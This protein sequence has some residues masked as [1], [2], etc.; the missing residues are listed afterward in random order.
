MPLTVRAGNAPAK[1]LTLWRIVLWMILLLAMLGCLQYIHHA[2]QVWAQLQTLPPGDEGVSVLRGMLA[3]DIGY[4]LVAFSLIVLCAGGILRQAW[5]RP[6]LQVAA[7]LLAGWA[8]LSGI[9]L[10]QQWND[11]MH[12]SSDALTGPQADAALQGVLAHARRGYQ[13]AMALKVA[14][15]PILLWLAWRLGQPA[16]RAQF[17]TRSRNGSARVRL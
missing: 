2:Q 16:V 4:L 9:W 13:M 3:W 15:I 8:A 10:M 6:L 14:A 17:R 7:V 5:A 11:F 12:A 1:G